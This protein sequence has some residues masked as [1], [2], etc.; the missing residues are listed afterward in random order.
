MKTNTKLIPNIMFVRQAL[1]LITMMTMWQVGW[2]V[3]KKN[4]AS[5]LYDATIVKNNKDF[6]VTDNYRSNNPN[7]S[8]YYTDEAGFTYILRLTDKRMVCRNI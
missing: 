7:T 3:P 1:L 5:N 8:F 4:V 2:A 6:G